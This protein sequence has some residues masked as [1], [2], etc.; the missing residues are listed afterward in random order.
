M[1]FKTESILKFKWGQ[2]KLLECILNLK[3][4]VINQ[5][6]RQRCQTKLLT[7]CCHMMWKKSREILEKRF[8]ESDCRET[9]CDDLFNFKGSRRERHVIYT[10]WM[11]M[12]GER[13]ELMRETWKAEEAVPNTKPGGK[14]LL[15]ISDAMHFFIA[16]TSIIVTI[17]KPIMCFL[18]NMTP[19]YARKQTRNWTGERITDSS[20]LNW[21]LDKIQIQSVSIYGVKD[22]TYR[23]RKRERECELEKKFGD[24]YCSWALVG[25]CNL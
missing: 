8:P 4:S 21:W 19:Q 12:E 18:N 24:K 16:N 1:S 22:Y 2:M 9:N 14:L 3:N 5:F 15:L 25:G 7:T 6:V 20:R 10:I 11:K 23:K 17:I 13:N